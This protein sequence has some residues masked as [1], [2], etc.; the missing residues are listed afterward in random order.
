[1]IAYY[2]CH[3]ALLC[4]GDAL[5]LNKM[6][7]IDYIYT[8]K[9]T[10]TH[11][12]RPPHEVWTT[13]EIIWIMIYDALYK[14]IWIQL[15]YFRLVKSCLLIWKKT[16][17]EDVALLHKVIT[18]SKVECPILLVEGE[19]LAEF[20]TNLSQTLLVGSFLWS[21]TLLSWFRCV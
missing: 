5:L 16:M 7:R 4:L 2:I 13:I 20:S 17:H 9:H 11:C 8:P 19:C 10:H 1:M 6:I 15:N 18:S 14:Y 21:W 12:G 3:S